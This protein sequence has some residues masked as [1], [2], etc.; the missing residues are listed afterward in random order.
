MRRVAT[1]SW[2]ITKLAHGQALIGCRELIF[3]PL[4]PEGIDAVVGWG[5]KDNTIAA[6]EFAHRH[7][8]PYL[9]LEDG[10]LRSV[11]LGV[12]GDTSL[13]MVLDDL[14]MYYDARRPSR[15]EALLN[16]DTEALKDPA[17]L[18]RGELAMA[19]ICKYGLSKYN[20][21]PITAQPLPESGGRERVLVVDQ[22]AGDLSVACGFGGRAVFAEML[23][24]AIAENPK[25][26]IIV[27][28][29]P[30][31][32]TGKKQGYLGA[33]VGRAQVRVLAEP[34]NA[35]RLLQQVDKVYVVTS[36]LGFEALMV[37]KPVVCFGGP[38]YAGWGLSDDRRS[39]Q[40]RT[41]KRTLSQVF[42]AAYLLYTRYIDPDTGKL[43]S[44]E[45]VIEHLRRQRHEFARNQGRLFCF[46]FR[47]WKHNYVRAYLRCPGN[48]VVFPRDVEHAESLGF[49]ASSHLVVW[50]QRHSDELLALA[51]KHGVDIWRM[52]D[53]FLRSVGLGS[54]MTVPASLVVD[55]QG[56]YY[57]PR[58][59][60]ELETIL[61]TST[62]EG[63]VIS[64]AQHLRA[65]LLDTGLS[66]YNVGHRDLGLPIEP[67]ER[68]VVLVPGQVEDDASI[69]LGC[70]EVCT[71]L[72]LLRAARAACP[73]AFI[74]FKPHPDVLSGNRSGNVKQAQAF[75]V[76]DHIEEDASLAQCLQ[77]ANQVH[78]MTSLVG[79][80]ALLRGLDVHVYGQPF[81]AGWGLTQDA[82]PPAR[83]TRKLS[84]DE[85]VAGTY[86]LY[87]RYLNRRTF[88]FTSADAVVTQ[89]QADRA[90][91]GHALKVSWSRRQLRKLG[92]IARGM[93]HAS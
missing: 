38:F 1:F 23:A 39:I 48:E 37:G 82:N 58:S 18:A 24:A 29:H 47:V 45:S 70:Q 91:G 5:L 2:G 44:I 49:D 69:Q 22:T 83:R 7:G 52:E 84:L 36:Q 92:H 4:S 63:E 6:V 60:S 61:E 59:P 68:A 88:R 85:L 25:A 64:A 90:R 93:T 86:L 53:G 28:T 40:R 57:D 43:G 9:R 35:I 19:S 66:K 80:E 12:D 67:G 21:S 56:I 78:V 51:S 10:F 89:L 73:E 11:G 62:F 75:E 79:F 41:R 26:E 50:G 16:A 55:R 87:P 3:W 30:D 74:I 8:L 72:G 14:G 20:D 76:C 17:L 81:Y 54:D 42:A 15:L 71:N 65:R 32:L 31:V 46:G 77:V 33:S 27:K 34:C 13:S